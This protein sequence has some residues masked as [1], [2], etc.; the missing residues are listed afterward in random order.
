MS[1]IEG[2]V[3]K[4][5]LLG[6]KEILEKSYQYTTKQLYSELRRVGYGKS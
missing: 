1:N 2:N 6:L 4:V 5:A 3:D